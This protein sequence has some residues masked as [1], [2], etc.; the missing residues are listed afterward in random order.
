MKYSLPLLLLLLGCPESNPKSVKDIIHLRP[1][2]KCV[3]VTGVHNQIYIHS[4]PMRKG[5]YSEI[6][7]FSRRYLG[8]GTSEEYEIIEHEK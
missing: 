6:H 1:G 5:E 2:Y 7:V 3:H 8:T 4:R